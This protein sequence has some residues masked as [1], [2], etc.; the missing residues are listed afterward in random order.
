MLHY[1]LIKEVNASQDRLKR[2]SYGPWQDK[3]HTR[4]SDTMMVFTHGTNAQEQ[5]LENLDL[6]FRVAD[7]YEMSTLVIKSNQIQLAGVAGSGK[8]K[9]AAK[10]L[11]PDTWLKDYDEWLD[12]KYPQKVFLQESTEGETL[13]FYTYRRCFFLKEQQGVYDVE[14]KNRITNR[15][16]IIQRFW[17]LGFA[18]YRGRPMSIARSKYTGTKS[19]LEEITELADRYWTR[20]RRGETEVAKKIVS[21][22]RSINRYAAWPGAW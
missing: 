18:S 2:N 13:E 20:G 8:N 21:A 5:S 14:T 4:E 9:A 19:D 22:Y 15:R 11:F 10:I 7:E 6:C 3:N 12:S 1:K 17:D 16:E